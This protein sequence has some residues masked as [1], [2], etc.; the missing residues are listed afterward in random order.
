MTATGPVVREPSPE[1]DRVRPLPLVGVAVGSLVAGFLVV[2][3]LGQS[4]ADAPPPDRPRPRREAAAAPAPGKAPARDE[5]APPP[6]EAA[7]P[8]PPAPPP[9][10]AAAPAPPATGAA[11]P[12][13]PA[14]PTPP[15]SP[16]AAAPASA[17]GSTV[18]TAFYFRCWEAGRDEPAPASACDRLPVLEQRIAAQL[19]EIEA[20]ASGTQGTLSLGVEVQLRSRQ[21]TYWA[22]RSSTIEP[23]DPLMRCVRTHLEDTDLSGIEGRFRKYTL[24]VPIELR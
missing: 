16:G 15:V 11:T 6:A 23:V 9:A 3:A 4:A 19:P 5:A 2:Y 12:A 17:R 8:A 7:P 22:G 18:G 20:C 24:F 1:D 21:A 14:P 10:E 13:A